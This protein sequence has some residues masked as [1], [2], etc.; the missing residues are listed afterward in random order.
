MART[1]VPIETEYGSQRLIC[2]RLF[3]ECMAG[4][5]AISIEVAR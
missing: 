1:A 4:S 3:I 5:Y 2:E